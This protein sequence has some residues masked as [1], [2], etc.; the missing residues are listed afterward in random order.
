MVTLIFADIYDK[1]KQQICIGMIVMVEAI[2]ITVIFT[3]P[4]LIIRYRN[5]KL[6]KLIGMIGSAYFL[7]ILVSLIISLLSKAGVDIN[8]NKDIGEI[9]SHAA[10]GIAIPLLLFSA[11]LKEAR[12]LSRTVLISFASL[13]FSVIMVTTIV[14]YTYGKTVVQGAHLSAMAIGLYTGGTPNLNAIGNIFGLSSDIIAMANLSDMIIGGVFYLFLLTAC[15]PLL[16]KILKP[17]TVTMYLTAESD[18]V[19]KEELN[20]KELKNYKSLFFAVILALAMT[21]FSALLG[22]GIWQI[23]G[24]KLVDILVPTMMIAVTIMGIIASFFRKVREA[25]GTNIVG[26]YLILVFSFALASSLDLNALPDNFGKLLLFFGF[27]TVVTF[28]FHIV[29]AK[30]FKIDADC[31]IVT[32]TA[33]IYGPAFIPAVTKQIDN[34][35]LTVPGLICGSLGYAIGTFLGFGFGILFRL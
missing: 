1:I 27:I 29:L 24:G 14:N 28:L 7:G 33:G 5:F 6:T 31:T 13:M 8:I 34:E 10:I 32:A 25:K 30:I 35:A 26:Q 2:Q 21:V 4:A 23:A 15:K 12:K 9:G 20:L 17:A 3:V 16:R 19:N 18:I 11:N 22:F